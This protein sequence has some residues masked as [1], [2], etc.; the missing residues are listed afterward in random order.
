MSGAP[1]TGTS[2]AVS[3]RDYV[4]PTTV[5]FWVVHAAAVV[6]V[7]FTGFS[8]SGVVLALASYFVR[9]S[10]LTAGYHRYFSHRSFKTSR[11]FQ[12]LLA[13][14]AQSAGQ[15]GAIWWASIHRLHHKHS[16]T[17]QDIHSPVRRGF[18][19]AHVGWIVRPEWTETD[20]TGVADLLRC[21][22]LRFLNRGLVAIACTT[23][24]GLA[25]L[26]IGGVHAMVWGYLV[27]TV[28]LWH[29]SFSI[30]SLAHLIGK[31][32]Y[33]TGDDSR[34]HWLLALITT[35]E[36]WHNNHHHYQS[37]ARQGFSWWQVDA[38]YYVVRVLALLGLVWDV[39]EPP[40]HVVSAPRPGELAGDQ[41][42]RAAA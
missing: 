15:G 39:R 6:G 5:G 11:W 28:L 19:Y 20:L 33:E 24:L 2:R 42:P 26:L 32:R 4:R 23:S 35:G 21:P 13:V 37:S 31:R 10:V 40:A 36:G 38:T 29:G 12:F 1:S 14:G 17:V 8:W 3:W 41:A 18:W 22:E 9:M 25:F 7:I 27:S 16:D 34:N 30:N